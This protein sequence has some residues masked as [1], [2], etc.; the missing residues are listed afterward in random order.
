MD[1]EDYE[2]L[3]AKVTLLMFLRDSIQNEDVLDVVDSKLTSIL[4]SL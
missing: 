4:D 1:K 2:R 3:A